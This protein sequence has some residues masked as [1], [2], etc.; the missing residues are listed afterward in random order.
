MNPYQT[1]Q[2]RINQLVGIKPTTV[3]NSFKNTTMKINI[4][5]YAKLVDVLEFIFSDI[6]RNVGGTF[7]S[8]SLKEN[9]ILRDE[10]YTHLHYYKSEKYDNDTLVIYVTRMLLEKQNIII[11]GV[12]L[13]KC[14]KELYNNPVFRGYKV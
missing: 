4:K 14:I 1:A 9:V 10:I 3:K 13:D 5:R 2:N 11:W 8:E 6:A 7:F 12:T